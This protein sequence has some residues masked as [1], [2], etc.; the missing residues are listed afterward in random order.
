MRQA[1][2][3]HRN[4]L[5]PR[6]HGGQVGEGFDH[7]CG[8]R[9][10]PLGL[11]QIR[12]KYDEIAP[13]YDRL[14]AVL[15]WLGI[16]SLPRRLFGRAEGRVLEVAIGT[17]KLL[18]PICMSRENFARVRYRI[19][20]LTAEQQDLIE[21]FETYRPAA[22]VT[23]AYFELFQALAV[24]NEWARID[25][26]RRLHGLAAWGSSVC[27]KLRHC[28]DVVVTSACVLTHS[29]LL[30]GRQAIATFTVTG[31][32]NQELQLGVNP[33]PALEIAV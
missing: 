30:Q 19:A 10:T 22:S 26:H 23:R 1:P 32:T 15:E 29:F 20:S 28:G 13:R 27:P 18:F 31:P 33:N 17:G 4:A 7:G 9:H 25:R 12:Q 14:E 5:G 21:S 24:L 8:D 16:R 11:D 3:G 6:L 2:S